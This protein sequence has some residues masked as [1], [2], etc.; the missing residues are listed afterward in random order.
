MLQSYIKSIE[1]PLRTVSNNGLVIQVVSSS[2]EVSVKVRK[3]S[4]KKT[5]RPVIKSANMTDN[6]GEIS[7]VISL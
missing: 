5:K 7:N 3:A 6:R 4:Y 1:K 2:H